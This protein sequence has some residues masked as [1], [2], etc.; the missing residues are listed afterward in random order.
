[1]KNMI[2]LLILTLAAVTTVLTQ[3]LGCS[4]KVDVVFVLDSSGSESNYWGEIK[5]WVEKTLDALHDVGH[6]T[7]A[8]VVIFDDDVDVSHEI[9]LEQHINGA[10]LKKKIHD[11]PFLGGGT[12][13]DLGM[14][15]ALDLFHHKNGRRPNAHASVVLFTDGQGSN[16]PLKEVAQPFH[17]EHIR[18]MVV[19]I[20]SGIKES[21]LRSMTKNHGISTSTHDHFFHAK[22]ISH[23]A[24]QKFIDNSIEGCNFAI[25]CAA[26]NTALGGSP[27]E[28]LEDIE[29]WR[30]CAIE[31]KKQNKLKT[32]ENKPREACHYFQW[33]GPGTQ[34]LPRT[35]RKRY[36]ENDCI[37]HSQEY[38]GYYESHCIQKSVKG[39]F[40]GSVESCIHKGEI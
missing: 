11:L 38:C 23:L 27:V 34:A 17:D 25:D 32:D 6:D 21:D 12:R 4:H 10:A 28:W 1:M 16:K 37:L 26:P 20:G 9:L 29:S 24:S 15:K 40:S 3:T 13:I 19:G 8:G 22:D 39:V 36:L 35:Q 2:K 14:E 30:K 5:E 33:N 18:V 7:Q 31:C